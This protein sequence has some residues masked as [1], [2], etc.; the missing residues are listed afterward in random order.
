MSN[1]E[2]YNLP[3]LYEFY[4]LYKRLLPLYKNHREYFYDFIEIGSIYGSANNT[5]FSGG[6]IE[7]SLTSDTEVLAL[8]NEYNIPI[9]LTFSNLVLKEEHLNDLRCNELLRKF[10]DDKNGII[11]S[12]DLHKR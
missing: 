9:R 2:Y 3:G 8:M 11:I 4:E 1:K 6:R 10:E 12:S 5:I 7:Y